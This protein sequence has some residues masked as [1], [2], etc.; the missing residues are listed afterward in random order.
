MSRRFV[1]FCLI[2]EVIEYQLNFQGYSNNRLAI[3]FK[4]DIKNMH[5]LAGLCRRIHETTN[6]SECRY[7]NDVCNVWNEELKLSNIT[8][9]KVTY[10]ENQKNRVK[11]LTCVQRRLNFCP[12]MVWTVDLSS[13]VANCGR[14]PLYT[15]DRHLRHKIH[16]NFY[17]QMF[18]LSSIFKT[19]SFPTEICNLEL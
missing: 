15:K 17:R 8:N 11:K 6:V 9:L 1:R 10:N 2:W 16:F 13:L 3:G 18:Q 7:F 5:I 14:G 4:L 19:K 12:S